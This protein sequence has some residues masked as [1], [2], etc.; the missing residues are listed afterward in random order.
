MC[1]ASRSNLHSRVVPCL[2]L[3]G[4]AALS[5][6]P[7]SHCFCPPS[8]KLCAIPFPPSSPAGFSPRGPARPHLLCLFSSLQKKIQAT[9]RR[10]G[11]TALLHFL[12]GPPR[13]QQQLQGERDLALAIAQCECSP[14][15]PPSCSWWWLLSHY[16]PLVAAEG[17]RLLG[18]FPLPGGLDNNQAVHM[19]ILQT[20]YKKL[21]CS[22]L[23]CPRYGAH[24]EE[25]GFQGTARRDLESKPAQRALAVP[26]PSSRGGVR[27]HVP[28]LSLCAAAVPAA[29]EQVCGCCCP[30][31]LS[32]V[33]HHLAWFAQC[34]LLPLALLPIFNQCYRSSCCS[35]FSGAVNILH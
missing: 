6:A 19:R 31:Q 14:S 17:S 22:R 1:G 26:I 27:S 9:V 2:V 32:Q 15:G 5:C 29:L 12:F 16:V 8:A 35:C 7:L 23:G 28:S 4:W 24:W 21:T 30:R 20:I 13:L 3:S 10:Q 25:L 11:L 34:Q 18:V 33:G